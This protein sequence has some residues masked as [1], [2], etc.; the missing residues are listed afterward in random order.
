MYMFYA[1]VY[2]IC[3]IQWEVLD[4][5]SCRIVFS[6]IIRGR[7][8]GLLHLYSTISRGFSGRR[9]IKGT[10]KWSLSMFAA[11]FSLIT[12]CWKPHGSHR[13]CS[14]PNTLPRLDE[15]CIRV[16]SVEGSADAAGA[17]GSR[18][19]QGQLCTLSSLVFCCCCKRVFMSASWVSLTYTFSS[20]WISEFCLL[21]V[22][23]SQGVDLQEKVGVGPIE[24]RLNPLSLV[25]FPSSFPSFFAHISMSPKSS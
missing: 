1:Y 11:L 16:Q 7:P 8:I 17:R 20:G 22:G 3:V 19:D 14:F 6:H 24:S 4:F 25:P 13:G 10:W 15:D 9:T 18:T 23:L 12:R 2:V 21:R 5:K